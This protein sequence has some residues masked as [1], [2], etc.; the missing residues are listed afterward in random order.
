MNQITQES[1]V[2]ISGRKERERFAK[3][4]AEGRF[5]AEQ[6]TVQNRKR[7]NRS[8]VAVLVMSATTGY[9]GHNFVE[10]VQA[11][12]GAKTAPIIAKSEMGLPKIERALPEKRHA[13]K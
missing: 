1:L 5:Q 11:D 3:V 12:T 8:I 9:V 6:Y 13:S 7:R 10:R 4:A 2:A